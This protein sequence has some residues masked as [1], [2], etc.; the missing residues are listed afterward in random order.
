MGVFYDSR[1]GWSFLSLFDL[2]KA[3][4]R[5]SDIDAGFGVNGSM[6]LIPGTCS[7][8]PLFR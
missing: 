4:E 2:R 8:D 7:D 6:W 5:L 3:L 1:S